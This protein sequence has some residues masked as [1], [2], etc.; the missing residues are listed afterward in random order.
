MKFFRNQEV[1]SALLLFLL[2]AAAATGSAFLW[3]VRFGF[4]TLGASAL[5]LLLHTAVTFRRY[6]R[7]R[8]LSA[9]IDRIL[10]GSEP[11]IPLGAYKEG[12]L[13]ILQSEIRKMTVRLREQKLQLQND[14]VYLANLIADISHQLRTPLT[15]INLLVSFL[16]EPELDTWRRIELSQEL[17]QLLSRIDWLI[18][19]LLKLSKL[20]AGTVSF[21]RE[22]IPMEKLISQCTAPLLVP[23][24][25]REQHLSVRAEGNFTGDAAWTAEAVGNII[26][27]CTEHTPGGGRI[28]ITGCE[29]AL[30]CEIVVSDTGSGIDAEDLPHLFERFY[31][32]KTSD[33]NNFGIGLA[34]ARAII[35]AQNGTLK[36][37]NRTDTPGA[38]FTARFYKGTV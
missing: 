1:R 29:N 17:M 37:E 31:K 38:V 14:K 6:Q 5:F 33:D 16:R 9:D 34:L 32:G 15:T 22:T 36:A 7:I 2:L 4:F 19:A 11:E 30:F 23:M 3:D 12:E 8:A 18:T 20:D 21:K 10:H 27:N 28:E 26:K 35:T 25:L 24:E 13:G